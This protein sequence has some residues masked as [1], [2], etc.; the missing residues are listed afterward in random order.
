[1]TKE[2]EIIELLKTAIDLLEN[3]ECDPKTCANGKCRALGYCIEDDI[4][5]GD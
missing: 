2:R 3:Q 5:Q 4:G 1:M